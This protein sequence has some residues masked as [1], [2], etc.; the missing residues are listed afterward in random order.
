MIAGGMYARIE[1]NTDSVGD[2][3]MNQA[4]SEQRAAAIVSY[5]VSRGIPAARLVA[6]GNGS[7]APIATNKTADGRAQNRRTD[8]LFIRR[9]KA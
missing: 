7:S 9:S 5:L 8:V 1:G 6:R 4:L 3:G 2:Y